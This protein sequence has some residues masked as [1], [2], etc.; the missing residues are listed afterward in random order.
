MQSE[1][2]DISNKQLE[3]LREIS[4]SI[5]ILIAVQIIIA[6]AGTIYIILF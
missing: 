5:K 4:L 1:L 6:I 3:Q 2:I